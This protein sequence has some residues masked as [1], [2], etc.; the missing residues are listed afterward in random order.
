MLDPN[1]NFD[2]MFMLETHIIDS[3]V[4]IAEDRQKLLFVPLKEIRDSIGTKKS[5]NN[6]IGLGLSWS[7][8]LCNEMGGDVT[9]K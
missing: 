2:E 5:R 1:E 6:N 3:G 9:L 8:S 7:K 4:G